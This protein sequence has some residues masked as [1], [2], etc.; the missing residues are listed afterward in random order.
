[1]HDPHPF[2]AFIV[3]GGLALFCAIIGV[4]GLI[5]QHLRKVKAA[6]SRE[7]QAREAQA[8]G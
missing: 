3:P 5:A 1:M 7:S 4:G 6:R 2:Y 8:H